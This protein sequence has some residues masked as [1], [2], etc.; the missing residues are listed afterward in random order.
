ALD[1]LLAAGLP[2]LDDDDTTAFSMPDDL[3]S[4]DEISPPDV[5]GETEPEAPESAELPLARFLRDTFPDCQ[6]TVSPA[7]VL[8][9]G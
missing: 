6:V 1:A 9:H 2:E 8:R 4:F 5:A 3:P 7:T